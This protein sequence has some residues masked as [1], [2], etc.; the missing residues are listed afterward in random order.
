[1]QGSF[2]FLPPRRPQTVLRRKQLLLVI[3][4]AYVNNLEIVADI[5]SGGNPLEAKDEAQRQQMLIHHRLIVQRLLALEAGVADFG[6]CETCG[7]EI[8]IEGLEAFW[9]RKTCKACDKQIDD[10]TLHRLNDAL[11]R[12]RLLP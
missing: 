8:E 9:A 12:G 3:R 1:M 10:Q 4:T 7:D 2:L 5:R 6:Y 11:K